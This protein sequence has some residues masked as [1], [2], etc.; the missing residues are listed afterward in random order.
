MFL[1][2]RLKVRDFFRKNKKKIY[3]AIVIIVVIIILN[4]EVGRRLDS[5]A[6]KINYEPHTPIVSGKETPKEVQDDVEEKI[7]E[8]CKYCN[9]KEY[10]NAYAMLTDECK[11]YVFEDDIEN[12]K[13]YIDYIFNGNKVYSIQ[14]YSNKDNVYVYNLTISADLM[15]TGMNTEDSK[16]MYI[17]KV[18]FIK[19]D[20]NTK[21]SVKGF[22]KSEDMDCLGEDDYMK[23]SI[24]KKITYY[25]K[26]TY[27]MQITNKTT[28]PIVI[29]NEKEKSEVL[30]SL[31]GDNR[32]MVLD[33]YRNDFIIARVGLKNLS[34]M[35][36]NKY[37]DESK[38]ETAIIFNKIRVLKKY[39]EIDSNWESE[40]AD[41][42]KLYS[43]QIPLNN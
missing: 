25:D 22:I 43:L 2:F 41:A 40:L 39:T 4:I 27:K 24:Y 20:N 33:N 31:G 16:S 17:D 15:A 38:K 36:F 28:Y 14:D 37:Y 29:A 3:I 5:Q 12:F 32:G 18:V 6:P 1:D 21:F 11:E 13:K 8:Y 23:I 10:E 26:V 35:T 19:D 7:E 9:N 30:L 42:V 34:E